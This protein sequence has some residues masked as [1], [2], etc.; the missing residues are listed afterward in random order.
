[1]ESQV[2]N[3][4]RFFL[5]GWGFLVFFGRQPRT[6]FH[7]LILFF[8]FSLQSDTATVWIHVMN[9]RVIATVPDQQKCNSHFRHSY[10][11]V[12]R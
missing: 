12:S 3:Q 2:F 7:L 5:L 8:C 9:E 10:A 4:I 1:M 11:V 6:V